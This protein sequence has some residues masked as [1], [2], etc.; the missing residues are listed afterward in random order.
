MT[1]NEVLVMVDQEKWSKTRKYIGEILKELTSSDDGKLDF[2]DL[3]RKLGFLIYV[4]RTY[5]GM[6]LTLDSWRKHRDADGW[7]LTD[8]EIRRAMEDGNTDPT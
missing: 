8:R 4:T 5:K 1:E 6:H 2:K 7:K 3:E